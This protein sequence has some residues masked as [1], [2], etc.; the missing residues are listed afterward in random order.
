MKRREAPIIMR[1]HSRRSRCRGRASVV[2]PAQPSLAT[3]KKQTTGFT[4]DGQPV[5]SFRSLL[6][7]LATVARNTI[8]TAITPLYPITVVTRPTPLQQKAF[9]L[10]GVAV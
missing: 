9:E 10:L 1:L 7:D 4:P 2:R 3:V 6:A 5:H 8:V